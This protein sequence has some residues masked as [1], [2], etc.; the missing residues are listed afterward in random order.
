MMG[1][2]K[3][4]PHQWG[5][6]SG[7]STRQLPQL[8][9]RHDGLLMTRSLQDLMLCFDSN[10]NSVFSLLDCVREKG[11]K[12]LVHC[13]AG[14]S[15]SPTICMAYLMKT[16]QFR[17]KEAFDF[18]KQRRNVI[19]PN[20]GFMGQL[21]QYESEILPS[22]PTP[23]PPAHQGEAVGPAFLD[24]LQTLS[25]DMQGAFCTFPTSVLAPLPTHS[26]VPE[27]HRSPV[28]TATSC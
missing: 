3:L 26:A 18:V 1:P 7:R 12:V 8:T 9:H 28:A 11:G 5:F 23:Q 20:F 14:V 2:Q 4:Y 25:P 15:R 10:P 27:L 13:E 21:L 16:K 24:H 17:L 19:S 6:K 22:T